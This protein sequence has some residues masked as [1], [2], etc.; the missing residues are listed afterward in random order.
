MAIRVFHRDRDFVRLPMIARDARF[1]V[2]PGIGAYT[3]NMNFVMMEQGEQNVPHVHASS[4]DTLF[5]L[6]GKGSI[7]DFTHGI[8]SEF[9]GVQ[10]IHV[11]IGIHHAEK[12]DRGCHIESV[13]GPSPAD[14]V[15]L[16][17]SG[18]LDKR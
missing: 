14:L 13:G 4:E 15:F 8:R 18:V 2:W 3:A 6:S 17:A 7:E 10:V 11:P 5:I 12:A 9:E 16:K 1:V